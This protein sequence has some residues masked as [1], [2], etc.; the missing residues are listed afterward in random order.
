[1]ILMNDFKKEYQQLGGEICKATERVFESGWHILGKEVEEFEKN[2]ASYVGTKYCVGVANGMEA[3]QISLM[4]LGIGKGDEVITVSNTAVATV[5]AISNTGATPVF[6]DIND[7]YLMDMTRLEEKITNKTKAIIPVH[8]FGQMADMNSLGIIAKKHNLKIIEDACQ[9]HGAMQ[10][11]KKAGSIGDINSFSFYPTKNL[12]AYGD[13]GAI[14]TNSKELYE[15]SK[16]LR[17]YGQKNRYVHEIKGINSRLDEIQAA[18]LGVKLNYLDS[19]IE[20]RN[21]IAKM[22]DENLLSIK[23]VKLPKT[24]KNNYHA[25]HLY[26]IEVEKRDELMAYLLQNGVQTII[27]YPIPVHKQKCFTEYNELVLA[28]TESISDKILSLPINPFIESSEIRKVIE[29][30]RKFYKYEK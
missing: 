4:A 24:A 12:G 10:K 20:K 23:Q 28:N 1:M 6:V 19:F 22:Y 21:E 7:Y 11:G 29:L 2:F 13:G 30:I 9:A 5:L 8:L 18:I 25:F 15:K 17:N 16:M 3:L 14:T 26:V 27:H